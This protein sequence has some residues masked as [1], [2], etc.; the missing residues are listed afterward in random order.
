M[1]EIDT[2]NTVLTSTLTRSRKKLTWAV[3]KSHVLYAWASANDRVEV[4]PGGHELTN[5]MIIGRNPNISTYKYYDTLPIQQT[6]EFTTVKYKWTRMAASLM[7]SQEEIDENKGDTKIFDLLAKKM[8]V[9]EESVK[10]KF[11]IWLYGSGAGTDPNGLGNL[12]PA[13]PTTGI[14]GDTNRANNTWWRTSS[15]NFAG[16]LNAGNIE[17]AMDDIK[18]DLTVKS[19]KPDIVIMGRNIWRMY[20]QAVRDKIVINLPPGSAAKRTFDLGFE[21]VSHEGITM[22]FDEDCDVN[23]MFWLNSKQLRLHV[24]SG[25]NMRPQNLNA[26]WNQDVIGKR[27]VWQG[28]WASWKMHR[29]HARV[30]N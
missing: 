16:T 21:G 22:T 12:V 25:V 23:T 7:I 24:L 8:Q 20:R 9:M 30:T 28:Q 26:P 29:T 10:E 6:D 2:L 11:S 13:D 15:Y 5:P 17:M 4:E 1:A 19:D 3:L 27:V 18:M 14:V